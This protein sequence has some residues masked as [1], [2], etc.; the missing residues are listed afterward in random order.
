MLTTLS[1]T[2]QAGTPKKSF[3]DQIKT[4]FVKSNFIE[5]HQVT[6][7]ILVEMKVEQDGKIIILDYNSS[8]SA[9]SEK[10][11]AFVEGLKLT[12]IQEEPGIHKMRFVFRI[13]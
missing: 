9:L 11:T 12:N 6:G 5:R 7:E 3:Q 8:N 13:Y 2:L 1:W 10:F 4:E